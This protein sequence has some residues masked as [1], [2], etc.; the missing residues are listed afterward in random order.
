MSIGSVDVSF[1]GEQ[2][3]KSGVTTAQTLDT[4]VKVDNSTSPGPP[5]NFDLAPSFGGWSGVSALNF[6]SPTNTGGGSSIDGN[7]STNKTLL[8]ATISL[9][10]PVLAGKWLWI[11]FRDIDHASNDQG[12][13]IDDFS[14]TFRTLD[15]DVVPEMSSFIV[16]SALCCSVVFGAKRRRV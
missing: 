3:R 11:G 5:S 9:A 2:W 4:Y 6:A 15:V 13:A 7:L 10:T 12:L 8:S 16:W 14:A 1:T